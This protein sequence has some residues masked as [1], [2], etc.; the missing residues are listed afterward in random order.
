MTNKIMLVMS[1]VFLTVSV[2]GFTNY[3]QAPDPNILANERA[4]EKATFDYNQGIY[5]DKTNTENRAKGLVNKEAKADKQEKK[6]VEEEQDKTKG[7]ILV[8]F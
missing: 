3:Q 8:K 6:S 5:N 1:T 7:Q 2:L 4:N